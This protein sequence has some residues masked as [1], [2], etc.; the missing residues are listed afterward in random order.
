MDTDSKKPHVTSKA[1]RT[2]SPERRLKE[3]GIELPAPPEPFGNYEEAVLMGNL[4]FSSGL[5]PTE[6]QAANVG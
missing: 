5:L 1:S 2:S 4:L 3:L 6:G